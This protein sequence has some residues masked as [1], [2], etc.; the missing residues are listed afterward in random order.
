MIKGIRKAAKGIKG[1]FK[2]IVKSKKPGFLQVENRVKTKP[3]S[4]IQ[5][6][7][8][9][10]WTAKPITTWRKK[11]SGCKAIFL[12]KN[13]DV[14]LVDLQKYKFFETTSKELRDIEENICIHILKPKHGFAKLNMSI[15]QI[16]ET[17]ECTVKEACEIGILKQDEVQVV[18]KYLEKSG[19]YLFVKGKVIDNTFR[20]STC[21]LRDNAKQICVECSRPFSFDNK[22]L[23]FVTK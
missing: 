17:I 15:D 10:P 1:L 18:G 8:F 5:K 22:L 2:K 19:L 9:N 13:P 3:K 7:K 21:W 14:N 4:A 16:A 6:S 20:L 23:A 12:N 11:C